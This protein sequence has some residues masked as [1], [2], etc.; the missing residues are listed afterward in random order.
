MKHFSS[1]S[2][3][4]KYILSRARAGFC[5]LSAF[6][7][8]LLFP[9]A[10]GARA[11]PAAPEPVELSQADGT[12]VKIF[13]KGDEFHSWNED[14]GGYAIL[15]DTSTRNWVYA[16]KDQKGAMK[17]T[18]HAVGKADPK[19]LGLTRHLL[20]AKKVSAAR[21]LR[22]SR[23]SSQRSRLRGPAQAPSISISGAQP[24]KSGALP[25]G[26]PQNTVITAGTL[27]NLVILARFSDQTPVNTQAEFISLFNDTG[28]TLDGAIG[29]VKDFYN[30][31]SYGNINIES[32]VSQWV[33]LPNTAAFYGAGNPDANSRQM[34]IDAINALD[35]V[36]F[37]FSTMD[38]NADGEVDGLDI[39][40]SG[41]GQEFSGNS[42][43]YIW[44]HQWELAAPVTKD[45]V[46]MQLYHTE[47]E[48]R[49]WDS[50]PSSQG[51]ARVGV[52]CHETGH[53]LGLPDL[54]DYDGD[55][56]GL[57]DFCLMAGGSWNGTNGTSPAHP[58]A[59]CKSRLG[60]V[61]PVTISASGSYSLPRIEDSDTAMYK[62]SGAGFPATEYFLMENKQGFGFDAA[63][64]GTT[65]GILIWHVDEAIA[66]VGA[67]DDQLHYKVDLEEASGTQHLQT[68]TNPSVTQ[69]ADSDYFRSGTLAAF[70]DN[71]VPNSKSYGNSNLG[72]E[73]SNVSPSG[74]TMTFNFAPAGSPTPGA[75]AYVYD[76]LGA[77]ITYFNS[78]T[79]LSANWAESVDSGGIARYWYA[80]GTTSGG[81]DIK[82][83]TDTGTQLSTTTKNLTLANG[84]I[85]YF[86]VKAENL[87]GLMSAVTTSNGQTADN[88]PP[89]VPGTVTDGTGSDIT[90][91][92]STSQ[93][94]ANWIAASDAE[95]GILK[96]WYAIGTTAGATNT[97]GGWIDNGAA[98]SVTK[99]S[100]T[101]TQ[102]QTY[103]FTV[104]AENGVNLESAAVNSNGQRVD[105]TPPLIISQV[106][107]GPGAD[108]GWFS[109]PLSANWSASSDPE[110]G[111]VKYYYAVGTSQG[112][113]NVVDWTDNGSLTSAT[114]TGITIADSQAYYFTVMAE[115]GSG[116]LSSPANSNGQTSDKSAPSAPSQVNDGTGADITYINSL[117][118]LSANWGASADDQ[119]GIARYLY[120]IGTTAGAINTRGWTDNGLNTSTTAVSLVLNN[121]QIYY[122]T[123]KAENL[124]GLESPVGNSNGQTADTTGPSAP[125]A[126]ADGL[127]S[128]VSYTTSTTQLA[129]N[130]GASSDGDSSIAR[131][132]YAIGTVAGGTN[133]ADW[134]DNGAG[135]SVT[136]T[137]LSLNDLA[138]YYFTVKAENGVGL[139]SAAANSNGIE[140]D[141]LAPT[142]TLPV[143][144]GTGLELD[145]V[146]S[147]NTLSAHWAA[148][149]QTSGI[150]EYFYAIGT[151]TGALNVVGWTSAGTATG[152][153]RTGLALAE[154][155]TYYFTVKSRT[156]HGYESL[157]ASSNGQKVD[158]TSPTVKVEL[159]SAPPLK[160]GAFTAVLTLNEASPLA[161]AP[162]F[163]FTP[164][165]GSAR[166]LALTQ[167]SSAVWNA[168]GFIDSVCSTGTAAFSFS[169]R[170]LAGNTGASITSGTSFEID[171]SVSSISGGTVQNEDGSGVTMPPAAYPS[172]LWLSISTA[173]AS[174]T[175][176][177]DLRTYNSVPLRASN[178]SMEF[179]AKDSGGVQV[180]TFNA[181]VVI[182]VA[183]PDA[184][185][186]GRVDGD[187]LRENLLQLYYLDPA[188]GKWVPVEGARRNTALN[189]IEADVSHF[190][191]YS[192]RS[193]YSGDRTISDIKA[194]P[195]PC[196]MRSG[197][198]TISGI[199]VDSA[200]VKISIYNAAGELVRTLKQG[201]GI[202]PFNIG[203]W[204]GRNSS[205]AKAASGLY[206]YV[207]KTDNHGKAT[208]KFVILW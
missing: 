81:T 54:Y 154:G 192:I 98:T 141:A 133:V 78:L 144:D 89:S 16:E 132:W 94:S 151:A 180:S 65:R 32:T 131:Y 146:S 23:D 58:S 38:G 82:D 17:K 169:A 24:L 101:L 182:R 207:V 109:S 148:S 178:L 181:P 170:D 153:T 176:P 139:Q 21:T 62:F 20:D 119:S 34:V 102:A 167:V 172:T 128:D 114:A 161:S 135:L 4:R 113:T 117:S 1:K 159:A 145:Y 75:I 84:Q 160:S 45:G 44:S 127:G 118:G 186:D 183:W 19:T 134:T 18:V 175:A 187:Y 5:I 15:K 206:L 13:L 90:Y 193:I 158:T 46:T 105:I 7:Y 165:G 42:A 67:N 111:V 168:A 10:P 36:G 149:F 93:L 136:R 57:G 68:N 48:R 188:P 61:T 204:D 55:S 9:F 35:A 97:T 196:Q 52:I 33:N 40:H 162:S 59:Y 74:D 12:K 3:S 123:I 164:Y 184:D 126:V 104:K 39:I 86:S 100:L 27:R 71:S 6:G 200:V 77:D 116:L 51:L 137:G 72:R 96:Y 197:A 29:S 199:P 147:L 198:L 91:T 76:G 92:A 177:A 60:W 201:D 121:G 173:A 8:F 130:W 49:G 26:G 107:D 79:Q 69:S 110:S 142:E 47:A 64:P 106:R 63:L 88:T 179:G 43:N 171:T 95:S 189:T 70:N 163:S 202:D 156:N 53:F 37:D 85:Y 28:Y 31:V 195:N 80:I 50:V 125:S 152:V 14:E 41:G 103:Y 143:L 122:F 140:T 155:A 112:A 108:G 66:D 138:T 174:V 115:N 191:V 56:E 129:A 150:A 22:N 205:G 124:A 87:I 11:V 157:P 30:E 83:W 194:Y 185:N 203:T 166:S 2:N 73:V 25:A 208:G 190:S 99:L 120:A